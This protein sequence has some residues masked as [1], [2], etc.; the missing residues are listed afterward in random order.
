MKKKVALLTVVLSIAMIVFS[1]SMTAYAAHQCTKT[2]II[3]DVNLDGS[4]DAIDLALL[5]NEVYYAVPFANP[6][7]YI[8]A[9]VNN[10]FSSTMYDYYLLRDYL[11]G[12]I[13]S[14]PAGETYTVY[15]GDLDGDQSVTANDKSL[16]SN[17]LLGNINLTSRQ[18]V[19]ADVNG[20]GSVNAIDLAIITQYINGQIQ[21]FP[22]CPQN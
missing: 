14:F 21:H 4:I 19:A 10:D 5:Y 17:Y 6:L 2:V 13:S 1:G 16:L 7:Q 8:A 22:V 11:L 15:Y 18:Y 12:E 20:D 9:D 3:G